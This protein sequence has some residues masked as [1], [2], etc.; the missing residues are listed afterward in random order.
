MNNVVVSPNCAQFTRV[1]LWDSSGAS[2][3]YY[4]PFGPGVLASLI[5][6]YS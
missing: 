2:G 3:G 6:L 4:F 1:T 5:R